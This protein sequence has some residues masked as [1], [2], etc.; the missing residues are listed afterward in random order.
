MFILF[1]FLGFFMFVLRRKQR[2]AMEARWRAEQE[3]KD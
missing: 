3:V 1:A 2:K